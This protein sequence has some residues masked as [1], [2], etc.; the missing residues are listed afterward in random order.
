LYGRQF[1]ETAGMRAYQGRCSTRPAVQ[2]EGLVGHV[3][4]ESCL[5]KS[6]Y[7]TVEFSILG[8]VRVEGGSKIATLDFWRAD[9][10]LFRTLVGGVPWN[11][12]LKGKRIQEGWLLLKKEVLKAQ[13]QA[14]PLCRKMSHQ[15]RRPAWMYRK[16][17]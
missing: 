6:D 14:I 16:Y 1:H 3:K 2:R 9:F 17:S 13:K 15:G 8:K 5:R 12:V 4:L 7:E 11:S 10:E